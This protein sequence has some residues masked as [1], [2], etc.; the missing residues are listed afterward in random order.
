[1][2]RPTPTVCQSSLARR[3]LPSG[4]QADHRHRTRTVSPR[5]F[6]TQPHLLDAPSRCPSRTSSLG[7]SHLQLLQQARHHSPCRSPLSCPSHVLYSVNCVSPN[8]I[9]LSGT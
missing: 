5:T 9:G 7:N 6:S 8:S 4:A 1:D 3:S 2:R